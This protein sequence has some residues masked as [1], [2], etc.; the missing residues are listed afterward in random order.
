[1]FRA[2]KII[3]A[4]FAFCSAAMAS[5]FQLPNL[6]SDHMVLQQ[7]I[8][9]SIW[10]KAEPGETVT[11]SIAELVQSGLVPRRLI[12]AVITPNTAATISKANV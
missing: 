3:L 12:L 5:G 7:G 10:G 8:P 9:L 6:F 11:V 4:F 1:M 2:I